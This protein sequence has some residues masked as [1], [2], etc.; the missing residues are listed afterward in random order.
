MTA[1]GLSMSRR[2]IPACAGEPGETKV[3][4]RRTQ[5]YPRVCGGAERSDAAEDNDIG[6]SP[7]VRGSRLAGLF[8]GVEPWSIPACAGEPFR[9]G[10][11]CWR[12]RVY[13]RVCGGATLVCSPPVCGVGLSPRVRGSQHSLACQPRCSRSIPACAGEPEPP[14]YS[15]G[16]SA[17]YPRV[18][19]GAPLT[20]WP[21]CE[22]RGLSPRVRGSLREELRHH[23]KP[24]SIPA[25]A[26]EPRSHPRGRSQ[27]WVYPRVC[28][29]APWRFDGRPLF[30]FATGI[31]LSVLYQVHPI[32]IHDG[33]GGLAQE[34]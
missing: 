13:P 19:G 9:S 22:W 3:H 33:L 14:R 2:S 30:L 23:S 11:C 24:G 26:G 25:C 1:S 34:S 31:P 12:R 8:H 32:G 10:W 15:G 20:L 6:L 21:L 16:Q 4:Q 7:R 18:C 27:H 5:V 28:G 17:V 29:G